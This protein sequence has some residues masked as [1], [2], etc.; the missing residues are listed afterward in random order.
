M[1][2]EVR[3]TKKKIQE[4]RKQNKKK[5]RDRKTFKIDHGGTARTPAKGKK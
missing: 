2:E 5:S 4:V 3:M 1:K